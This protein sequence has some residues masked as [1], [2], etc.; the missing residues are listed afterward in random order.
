[1]NERALRVLEFGRIRE[2]LIQRISSPLG[3]E[4]AEAL[5]PQ[6]DVQAVARLQE[7]TSEARAITRTE[8]FPLRGLFDVRPA[9]R[10]AGLG[11]TVSPEDLALLAQVMGVSRRS[12]GFFRDKSS[13]YPRLSIYGLQL[14]PLKHVEDEI[15]ACIGESGEVL[16]SASDKLR[17]LR[18][19]IR[20]IHGG[21][22]NKLE[23][24]IRS[25]TVQK[26]LQDAIVTVRNN[27]Y[28]LPVKAEYK[29][30]VPGIIHDQSASGATLFIEPMV[31]VDMN[32]RLRQAEAQE[33]QEIERILRVLSELVG[34][35]KDEL[36]T[37]ME[38]LAVLDL[39]M[40]KGRLSY[41]LKCSEPA[42]DG[43]SLRL[44]Q[45]RHP[46]IPPQ[47]VVPVDVTL[48]N[49]F[50]VLLITGP[51]T[52]GKTVTLKTIGLLSLM[53]QSGLHIPVQEGSHVRVFQSIYAD[54]GDE[55]SIEQSLSTFSSHMTN[56]TGI[57]KEADR[58]SLVLLD[59]LGAGTDPAE[60]AAL[61]MSIV[62]CLH[63]RGSLVVATTHYSELKAYAHVT[64]GVQNASVEFDL[65]TLRPTYH[66][67]IG[68]PGKSNAFEISARL[69][70]DAGVIAR[71][72][73]YLTT[74]ALKVEDLLQ[75]LSA[76]RESAF[77]DRRQAAVHKLAAENLLA[78]TEKRLSS[79][80]NKEEQ[81]IAAARTEARALVQRTRR[82]MDELLD[83][84][85]KAQESAPAADLGRIIEGARKKWRVAGDGLGQPDQAPGRVSKRAYSVDGE[86]APGDDVLIEHLNQKAKILEIQGDIAVVQ[87]GSMRANVAL[88]GLRRLAAAKP[89]EKRS[90]FQIVSRNRERVG[91]ELDL[92]GETVDSAIMRI[93]K[94]LDDA[95]IAGFPQVHLI[96]G[97]GTGA[98]RIGVQEYLRT[99]PAVE[100]FRYGQ[101]GE[102]GSGVTVVKFKDK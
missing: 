81:L 71:A 62:D 30:Q 57:V 47:E 100:S 74:D 60:G 87:M 33:E 18:A 72:R 21:I 75:S 84:L 26:Y 55:Q 73:D 91:L 58:E 90:T 66:L 9:I 78:D 61:A 64:D 12:Q 46:L 45:A 97:K 48:G 70:L 56:I 1:M 49:G 94:Y 10:R 40:A 53:A 43:K 96:H 36:L 22:K 11:A 13:V 16:D 59:E 42:L 85:R 77:E 86:I 80:R 34:S 23:S 92:R 69:G 52:G 17:R 28:V 29:G 76:A 68:L 63:A 51:N 14:T 50:S 19:D 38:C 3:R 99:H 102:G 93:D 32:N 37:N 41:E 6:T 89:S 7:E 88:S 98:L 25:A 44:R 95:L 67:T 5:T 20:S 4:L 31:I 2:M 79:V 82:E 24:M 8:E 39:A 15:A 27:R 54:I 101:A 65:E 83:E 35:H